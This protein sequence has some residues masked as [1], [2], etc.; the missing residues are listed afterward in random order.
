MKDISLIG[1]KLRVNQVL[2]NLLGNAVKFTDVAGEVSLTVNTLEETDK[3]IILSY[4]I[5]DNGIGMT[6][7]QLSKLFIPF[8]QINSSIAAKFG[9][10]GLGLAISQNLI[11]MMGGE[12]KAESKPNAGSKFYFELRFEKADMVETESEIPDNVDLTG[13][14]ILLV[15]DIDINRMILCEILSPT[16]A[17]NGEEAIK[18]LNDSPVGYYGLILMD[19]QMPLMDGYE[20][21]RQIRALNREDAKSISIIAMTANAY[22]EDVDDALASGMD[23]HLAKPVDIQALMKILVNFKNKISNS[24]LH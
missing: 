4:N 3:Y 6:E 16:G 11:N 18:I 20:A 8:E 21:T 15:D 10:T 17:E 19:M 12:I 2:I 23:G 13:N 24:S 7:E 14:R 9:G 5:S 22:K 1:D